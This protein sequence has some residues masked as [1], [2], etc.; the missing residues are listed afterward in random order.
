M[1][2]AQNGFR[3]SARRDRKIIKASQFQLADTSGIGRTRIALWETGHIN[4]QQRELKA[5]AR[6][7]RQLALQRSKVLLALAGGEFG[8][9]NE[10]GT[11]AD[12]EIAARK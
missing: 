11:A 9:A 12:R 1:D 4:L 7:L 2:R 10:V 6:A 8:R 3:V 5:I